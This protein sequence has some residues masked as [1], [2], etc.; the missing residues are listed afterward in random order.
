VTRAG[1]WTWLDEA[2]QVHRLNRRLVGWANYFCLGRVRQAYRNM[3]HHA[4]KRLRQWLCHKHKVRGYR[5]TSRFSDKYLHDT[6][7]L[8]NIETLIRNRPW[9]KV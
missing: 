1:E 6:L 5:G 9:A 3:N 2:T 4:V 7:G 8:I